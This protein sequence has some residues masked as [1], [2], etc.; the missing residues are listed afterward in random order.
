MLVLMVVNYS[1]LPFAP[2][3]SVLPLPHVHPWNMVSRQRSTHCIGELL[4]QLQRGG[5]RARGRTRA[6]P[7][8]LDNRERWQV[9]VVQCA[10]SADRVYGGKFGPHLRVC[11]HPAQALQ[12]QPRRAV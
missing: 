4:D 7:E 12:H 6:E 8:Q 9:S 1:P 10:P 2:P 11:R 3:S 5:A